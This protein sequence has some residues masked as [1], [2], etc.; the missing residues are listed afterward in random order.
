ML[1][2][3]ELDAR[4]AKEMGDQ[5]KFKPVCIGAFKVESFTPDRG[6]TLS[7]HEGHWS[8]WQSTAPSASAARP[9]VWRCPAPVRS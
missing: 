6:L 1:W 9:G 2:Y 4:A 5:F 3:E 8:R 7:A